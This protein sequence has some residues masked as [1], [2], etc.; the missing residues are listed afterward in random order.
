[1]EDD[2]GLYDFY[3]FNKLSNGFFA[4]QKLAK[5][6]KSGLNVFSIYTLPVIARRNKSGGLFTFGIFL[7][8]VCFEWLLPDTESN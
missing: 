4:F 1:M 3:S 8:N 2:F 5:F 7:V 6:F